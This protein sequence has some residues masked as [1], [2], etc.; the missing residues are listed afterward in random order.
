MSTETAYI[1]GNC[2]GKIV[3]GNCR[4]CNRPL[5]ESPDVLGALLE[6]CGRDDYLHEQVC[7]LARK[8]GLLWQCQ[9]YPGGNYCGYD[10]RADE[11]E[12][13]GCGAA[14]PSTAGT[15]ASKRAT[16]AQP[17][18]IERRYV[19]TDGGRYREH[20]VTVVPGA[21]GKARV[22]ER[23]GEGTGG[24]VF[25]GPAELADYYARQRD[26]DLTGRGLVRVAD[27][28]NS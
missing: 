16:P 24:P 6:A 15:P 8:A 13:G 11:D 17:S 25:N 9:A 5:D 20:V 4:D 28:R 12:C 14:R 21:D 22:Y 27:V 26:A 10:N 1:C 23:N 19:T 3:E 2:G 7:G 18:A